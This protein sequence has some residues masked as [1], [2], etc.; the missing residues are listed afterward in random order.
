MKSG[1]FWKKLRKMAN[2]KKKNI[3]YLLNN[4]CQIPTSDLKQQLKIIDDQ[5]K[6]ISELKKE[7]SENCR[8]INLSF[9]L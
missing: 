4:T 3:L 2:K 7:I 1:M 8:N 6:E 5:E 9:N